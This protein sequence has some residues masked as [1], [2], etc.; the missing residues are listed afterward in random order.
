MTPTYTYSAEVLR[1]IDGDTLDLRIDLGF[2]ITT[3][4]RVRLFGINTPE[5]H[6]VK[7]ESEEYERGMAAQSGVHEWLQHNAIWMMAGEGDIATIIIKSHDGKPL[8]QGK[9]GR[10]LVEV[11]APTSGDQYEPANDTQPSLNDWLVDNDLAERK[12]Y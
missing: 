3:K 9:Y 1:V 11:F 2:R 10:W 7:K 4:Q 5:I 12:T 6:G 8:G